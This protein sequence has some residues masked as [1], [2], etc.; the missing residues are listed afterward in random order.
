MLPPRRMNTLLEMTYMHQRMQCLYHNAPY[1]SSAF[2]L[3]SNHLCAR[4]NF[5]SL[6]TNILA[7]HEDEVW[8]IQWS[9]DGNYLASASKDKKAMIWRLEVSLII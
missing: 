1:T 2:S 5:P 3:F 8:N 4:E 6:P 7:G 9:H